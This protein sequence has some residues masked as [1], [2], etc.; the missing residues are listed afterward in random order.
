MFS[1]QD[2]R[3]T[4]G[5]IL[6]QIER[7]KKGYGQLKKLL[8][9]CE[10]YHYLSSNLSKIKANTKIGKAS[11][12]NVA[13]TF[14]KLQLVTTKTIKT[15][16]WTDKMIRQH[17]QVD[18][19]A[20]NP[21]YKSSGDMKLYCLSRVEN[22]ECFVPE[23]KSAIAIN[24]GRRQRAE[25]R[26]EEQLI[27]ASFR[28]LLAI[29]D[30]NIAI[31]LL[32]RLLNKA[33]KDFSDYSFK[34]NFYE[35]KDKVLNKLLPYK[36]QSFVA[37]KEIFDDR[38]LY[39]HW[40]NV[41]GYKLSFHS[42]ESLGCESNFSLEQYKIRFNSGLSEEDKKLLFKLSGW[43]T[44]KEAIAGL[45]YYLNNDI[46]GGFEPTENIDKFT[47]PQYPEPPTEDDLFVRMCDR[48]QEYMFMH[49]NSLIQEIKRYQ[50]EG[51]PL[52]INCKHMGLIN[53]YRCINYKDCSKLIT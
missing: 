32:L 7:Q 50:K 28:W 40:F 4:I 53:Q 34:S 35:L 52:K 3:Y 48:D 22:L 5:L 23:I 31:A 19:W 16:G 27:N 30:P 44:I 37:R 14:C 12:I 36:A 9:V 1:Y 6:S 41:S 25:V 33:I 8:L 24:K 29:G 11:L 17:L 21:Y 2:Q 51:C 49:F 43:R 26:R 15:R 45:E 42:Y 18:I 39:C 20:K 13:N 38:L 46:S 47:P 10:N